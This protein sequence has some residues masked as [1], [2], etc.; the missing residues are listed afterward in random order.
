MAN[1]TYSEAK[2]IGP[3]DWK[4]ALSKKRISGKTW[5]ELRI[6]ATSWVTCACGN[7]CAVIPRDVSGEPRDKVLAVLGGNEGFYGCI[8]DRNKKDALY[9]L[10]LI[11][12]RSAH[13]IKELSKKSKPIGIK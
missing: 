10:S 1:K 3:F 12:L 11:E 13:I 9:I 8:R 4:K 5:E 7:Q 6:K 2:G